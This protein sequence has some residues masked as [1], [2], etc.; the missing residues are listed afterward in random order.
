MTA[1]SEWSKFQNCYGN[2]SDYFIHIQIPLSLHTCMY[3]HKIAWV[4]TCV[5]S[6]YLTNKKWTC[7]QN[8]KLLWIKICALLQCLLFF[9]F[10][11]CCLVVSLLQEEGRCRFIWLP[12]INSE[13]KITIK[14]FIRKESTNKSI[15]KKLKDVKVLFNFLN[16]V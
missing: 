5:Q 7:L 11:F 15:Q 12:N 14:I 9:F 6:N 4:L 8:S 10:L 3:S 2:S 13:N 16:I 1:R